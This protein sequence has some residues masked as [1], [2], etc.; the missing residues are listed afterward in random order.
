MNKPALS[1]LVMCISGSAFAC[2]DGASTPDTVTGAKLIVLDAGVT[3]PSA[4]TGDA[5]VGDC[6]PQTLES[7]LVYFGPLTGPGVDPSTGMLR[8]P[9]PGQSFHAVATY[10]RLSPDPSSGQRLLELTIPILALL[11]TQPGLLGYQVARSDRCGTARTFT[12]WKDEESVV[13]FVVTPVHLE[14]MRRR[15]EVFGSAAFGSYASSQPGELTL[16]HSL[17]SLEAR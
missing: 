6:S 13:E 2:S 17:H 4:S 9:K 15:A 5:A 14:A 11:P 8:A 12:V 7:D 3:A 1:L 16:Q 10:G